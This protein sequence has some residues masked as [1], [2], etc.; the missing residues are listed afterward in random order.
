MAIRFPGGMYGR[1]ALGRGESVIVPRDVIA[2]KEAVAKT[3]N[4]VLM[5]RG[6]DG[7]V[8]R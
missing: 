2:T 5:R 1:L 3:A 7:L 6:S 8:L 4:G